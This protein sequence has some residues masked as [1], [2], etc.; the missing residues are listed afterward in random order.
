MRLRLLFFGRRGDVDPADL[1]WD[2]AAL[3]RPT[4]RAA[5]ARLIRRPLS[6]IGLAILAVFV[7]LALFPSL[8]APD[9]PVKI[10]LSDRLAAPSAE[11]LFG[12]DDFGRDIFSRVVHGTHI[13]L[14]I[15]VLV[16]AS[17]LLLGGALGAAAGYRGGWLDELVMRITDVFM[18]FP[19]ILLPMVVVVVLKPSLVNTTLALA[20][21]WWPAYARL[22]RGQTLAVRQLPYVESAF[23]LGARPFRVLRR[24]VI[25]NAFPP[26]LVLATMDLG[27]VVLTAAGLGFLG[28]GAQPPT[29]EWGAMISDGLGFFL[30]AWWYPVFPGIAIAL[31]VLA[32]NLLG[33]DLRDWF[34][35]KTQ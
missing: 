20:V 9:D 27:F 13:S 2:P 31:T 22:M 29:P 14:L 26:L 24:Y 1:R 6:A 32:F 30:E 15:A 3:E 23:A 16:V 21:V 4:A 17:A 18:A 7:G 34:D 10:R 11:H 5:F 19:N 28:L 35:P 12:T 8:I 33:D 25:P